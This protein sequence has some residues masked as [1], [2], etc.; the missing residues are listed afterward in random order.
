MRNVVPLLLLQVAGAAPSKDHWAPREGESLVTI[1]RSLQAEES[2]S[3]VHDS[4]E[5]PL[6]V[7]PSGPGDEIH[8]LE[9]T[10]MVETSERQREPCSADSGSSSLW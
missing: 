2:S 7:Q 9:D 10:T 1:A 4:C 5:R 3:T 6:L 8:L